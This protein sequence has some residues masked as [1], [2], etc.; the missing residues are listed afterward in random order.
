MMDREFQH[1]LSNNFGE[2]VCFD[3]PMSRHTSLRV[4]GPADAL[5]K[6][7]NIAKLMML[8]HYCRQKDMGLFLMGRGTNLLVHDGGIRGVV[9]KLNGEFKS[10]R[11]VKQN[12]Q[13][14]WI[15]AASGASLQVLCRYAIR[16]GF[17]GLN[18]ALG[19]PGSVGGAIKGNAGTRWGSMGDVIYEITILSPEAEPAIRLRKDLGFQYR[20][21]CLNGN[22]GSGSQVVPL[23]VDG[24]FRLPRRETKYL[25]QEAKT[26][27]K[28]RHQAQ[29]TRQPNAGCFFKN[30]SF[31]ES[32]GQL[33]EQ[34][35]LK[36]MTVG[37]AMVSPKHANFIVNHAHAT[38]ADIMALKNIIQDAVFKRF[39][40]QL[41]TEVEIVGEKT[42]T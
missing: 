38:A 26:I 19:I 30:P 2:A 1:W 15:R 6:V 10:I 22:N 40:V 9:V 28:H 11:T 29:P 35:G 20:R 37:G 4:G 23:I 3:E 27:L 21:L 5:V 33:I 18:F 41:E 31:S 25:E 36:G 34:A 32:A 8:S 17:G 14:A 16:R 39:N 24:I 42:N 13:T 12:Q 7:D